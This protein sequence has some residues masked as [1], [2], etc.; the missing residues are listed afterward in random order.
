MQSLLV[1]V[2]IRRRGERFFLSHLLLT[3]PAPE[4]G[5]HERSDGLHIVLGDNPKRGEH[6]RLETGEP[7]L[8]GDNHSGGRA[9]AGGHDRWMGGSNSI[10]HCFESFINRE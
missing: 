2:F 10:E 3:D 4:H 7:S 1:S 5:L 9:L 6:R 8:R